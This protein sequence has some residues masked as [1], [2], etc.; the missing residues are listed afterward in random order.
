[1]PEVVG[2]F[3][4]VSILTGGQDGVVHHKRSIVDPHP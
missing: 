1:M 3:A 4:Q 2:V